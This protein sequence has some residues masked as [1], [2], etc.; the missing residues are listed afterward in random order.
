[1][2]FFATALLIGIILQGTASGQ[3][4]GPA[5]SSPSLHYTTGIGVTGVLE[6]GN[7]TGS[8]LTADWGKKIMNCQS[9]LG[10]GGGTIDA[11]NFTGP[12]VCTTNIAL[13]RQVTLRIYSGTHI[14]GTCSV[15][16]NS[17][18]SIEGVGATGFY[19]DPISSITW[20][21]TGSTGNLVTLAPNAY[22]VRL[23]NVEFNGNPSGTSGHG[24]F[25]SPGPTFDPSNI[26]VTLD[27]VTF[28]QFAQDGIHF[29]D[30]VYQVD[31]FRCGATENNRYGWFQSPVNST[32]GPNQIDIFSGR[33]NRN[34]VAQIYGRG[35]ATAAQFHMWGGSVSSELY[36]SG[37]SYCA[38]FDAGANQQMN[39]FFNNVHFEGCGGT[40]GGGAFIYWNVL[41]GQ[42]VLRDSYF[43]IPVGQADDVLLGPQFGGWAVIGPGNS[44]ATN[45]GGYPLD[46]Q[47]QI[48]SSRALIYDP[49]IDQS[50]VKNPASNLYFANPLNVTTQLGPAGWEYM[51]KDAR[52]HFQDSGEGGSDFYLED[53]QGAFS[54][55]DGSGNSLLQAGG[56]VIKTP[57]PLEVGNH[58]NM[59]SSSTDYA[60]TISLQNANYGAHLFAVPFFNNPVC[61]ISPVNV[62][63]SEWSYNANAQ[64]LYVFATMPIT[65]N[66]KYICV[67]APN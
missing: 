65:V 30:N 5:N 2:R 1:M 24:L 9:L 59:T 28:R 14:S 25:A 56:G 45:S 21:Y 27:H 29:E 44:F 64:G 50:Q 16:M 35:G 26:G 52:L 34:G 57:A 19:V 36:P 32:I 13:D 12:Q 63:K 40:S 8:D 11:S 38:H 10:A 33:F 51:L 49:G 17:D 20:T 46:N 31:C 23:A 43:V 15:T 67:G 39:A 60:G 41:N 62:P 55:K 4:R 54:L 42:F 37:T 7:C 6:L 48:L 18:D 47:A 22:S 53:S 61:V 3:T 58:V 66:F